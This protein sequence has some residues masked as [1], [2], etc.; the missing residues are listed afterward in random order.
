MK[1]DEKKIKLRIRVM[2][3][4]AKVLGDNL[5]IRVPERT[6][7]SEL[8]KILLNTFRERIE[9]ENIEVAFREFHA[10]NLILVNGKEISALNGL[11]TI[12]KNGD[13]ILIVNLT[14]GG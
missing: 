2:G 13:E 6:D 9:R 1:E 10:H 12:L 5:E 3:L 7:I 4:M 8:S 14:R 11:K